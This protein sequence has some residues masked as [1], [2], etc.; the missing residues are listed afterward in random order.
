M[1]KKLKEYNLLIS[2]FLILLPLLSLIVLPLYI[3][4]NGIVWQEPVILAVGWILSGLGIT[5]GYHRLFAHR[6]FRSHYLIEWLLMLYGTMAIQ[7]TILN[8]C[9][10]HRVHH[11]KLDTEDDPYSIKKG[12]FHAHMGWIMK[13]N[14]TLIKGVKDLQA[15]KAVVFQEKYYWIIAILLSFV[16]PLLIGSLY[17]RPWGGLIWGGIVRVTLVHHFTWFI[18]SLCHYIGEKKYDLNTSAR[19][20]WVMAILTFG[21]GYHNFHHKFQW[22]YRNGIKWYNFD[23][24]KWFIKILSIF[25]MT[26]DLKQAKEYRILKAQINTI[27]ENIKSCSNNFLVDYK[28]VT[29]KALSRIQYW[30]KMEKKYNSFSNLNDYKLLVYKNKCRVIK[31]KI[32]NSINTL[33]LMLLKCKRA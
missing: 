29:Q 6:S 2:S 31:L 21:E 25:R 17:G 9:S 1:F 19:D 28:R 20:S 13:N 22:D 12:F 11:K 14:V 5:V 30:E 33:E 27:N 32:Y 15:K 24:S 3:I 7:N 23:P 4:N 18:N 16:F 26:Y 10:D 8:W